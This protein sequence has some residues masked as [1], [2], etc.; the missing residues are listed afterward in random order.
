MVVG[1]HV[2]QAWDEHD[3]GLL[4][5]IGIFIFRFIVEA[6]SSS[7]LQIENLSVIFKVIVLDQAS[8]VQ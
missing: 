1:D 2:E 7:I 5:P 8:M 3:K 4:F 6:Y